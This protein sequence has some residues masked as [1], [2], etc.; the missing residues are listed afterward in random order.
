[1][2]IFE[3][4]NACFVDF[5]EA[6]DRIPRGKLW[7]VLLQN[8]ID[9]PLLTAIKSLCMH[10]EVC[11]RVNSAT[12]KPFRASKGPRQGCSLSPILFLIYMDGIVRKSESYGEVSIRESTVQRLLFADD[13]VLLDSTKNGLQQ[14]LDRFSDACSVARMKI[15]TTKVETNCLSRQP[16]QCSLQSSCSV[17]LLKSV[18]LTSA[19]KE[20][21]AR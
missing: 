4:V 1:M 17:V 16:N 18:C 8:G 2:R 14:T 12:I 20:T 7:A 5:E 13:L 10:S 15:S 9:G 21:S 3:R 6:Y 11:V 19:E